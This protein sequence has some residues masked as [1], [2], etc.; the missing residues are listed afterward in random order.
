MRREGFQLAVSRPQ[1][2]TKE[3][4][5]Q[6]CEP[7]EE[8]MVDVEEEHQGSI[9]QYLAERKGELANMVPDGKGRVR[10][11]YVIPTRGLIG[12]HS[13]FLTMTSGTGVMHHVFDHYG[14]YAGQ[15]VASRT[16]GVL[17]ANGKG[18]AAA[19]ALWNLQER[20]E[21]IDWSTNRCI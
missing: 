9:M 7:Y 13:K 5:G 16:R 6:L 12:F 17:I 18:V 4:D 8:L 10:L 21:F 2:I 14:P 15:A 1:V 19:Y 20:G 3:I 11:D